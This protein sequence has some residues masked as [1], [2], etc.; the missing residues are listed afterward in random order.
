MAAMDV[1][2]VIKNE[3]E[4]ADFTV[5]VS[6]FEIYGNKLYDLLNER[7]LVKCLESK[8]IV[9]FPGLS[10]HAVSNPDCLMKLIEQGAV[11]RSRG[12][13]SRNADSR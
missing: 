7:R 1:F 10:K 11:N 8:G 2:T 6:L 5:S 4:G 3:P 9:Y 12:A 13:T